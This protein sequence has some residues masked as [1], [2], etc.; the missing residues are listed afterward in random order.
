MAQLNFYS[1][2]QA[3]GGVN[4]LSISVATLFVRPMTLFDSLSWRTINLA[5][6]W[7]LGAGTVTLSMSIG[8]YSLTGSTLSLANSISGTTSRSNDAIGYFSMNATSATQ[9]IT[10]GN[11]WLGMLGSYGAS[12]I[13]M[14]GQSRNPGNA[15]PG[16]FIN[17][18]MTASTNALPGSIATS[19][20]DI[21]GSDAMHNP[22]II[23]TA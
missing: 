3:H 5:L 20:L 7:D 12:S 16:A 14:Y 4:K 18:R 6:E 15:F 2:P 1:F 17:G 13:S 8:L 21:T 23:L 9:N 10:P 11:W 22:F 19:D